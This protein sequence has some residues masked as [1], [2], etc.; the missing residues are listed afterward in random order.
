MFPP[1]SDALS[2]GGAHNYSTLH[3]ALT[4]NEES[5]LLRDIVAIFGRTDNIGVVP[6]ATAFE[7][8]KD[9]RIIHFYVH[10][11]KHVAPSNRL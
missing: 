1:N 3:L 4:S 2:F 7:V 11:V 5:A 6:R 8:H 10:A 9:K